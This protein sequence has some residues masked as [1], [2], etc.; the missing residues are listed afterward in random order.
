MKSRF[1]A[2]VM[3]TVLV[4][5]ACTSTFRISKE[6]EGFILGSRSERSDK[7]LCESGDLQRVLSGTTLTKELGDDLYRYLCSAE[8]SHEKV[9]QLYASM[10]AKQQKDLQESFKRN[11]YEINAACG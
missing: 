6:G 8:Q 10:S 11:G 1:V 7:M 2:G 5:T 3:I 9:N 4:A